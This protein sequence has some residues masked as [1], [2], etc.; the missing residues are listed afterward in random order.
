MAKSLFRSLGFMEFHDSGSPLAGGRV[1]PQQ[2]DTSAFA[3]T[4]LDSAGA[5]PN[6]YENDGDGFGNYILLDANGRYPESVFLADS[7]V[8]AAGYKFVVRDSAKAIQFTVT[9]IPASDPEL[10][11]DVFAAELVPWQQKTFADS[12]INLTPADVGGA[13]E[14]DTT[15]GN[16]VV[17]LPSAASAGNGKGFIFKK[18]FASNTV[19]VNR[20][21]SDT[22]DGATSK[23]LY[24][25]YTALKISSNGAGWRVDRR[26]AAGLESV[27]LSTASA[28]GRITLAAPAS[29]STIVSGVRL[30]HTGDL[31]LIHEEGGS[32]RGIRFNLTEAAAAV[33]SVGFHSGNA[34]TQAQMET[35]TSLV[36]P[37]VP[38]R[39]HSHPAHPKAWGYALYS[40]GTPSLNAS[41]NVANINDAG[42][43]VL[44]VTL[45]TGFTNA[46]WADVAHAFAASFVNITTASKTSSTVVFNT[47]NS[48]GG[49]VDPAAISFSC[50]GDQA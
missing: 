8:Y 16:V 20:A 13:Y 11:G 29:G 45:T 3:E 6:S 9:D 25:Q 21:G 43:G 17:N 1:Y 15:S 49:A 40:G 10:S 4:Y 47:F 38:G 23:V 14:I 5:T 18:T 44:G 32:Q 48:G 39:Q 46:N 41:Y 34:A 36:V 7:S 37:V 27:D 24:G 28:G 19:T 35:G 12:P 42:V 30:S 33:A 26:Y 22:I 50:F 31:Y 2:N